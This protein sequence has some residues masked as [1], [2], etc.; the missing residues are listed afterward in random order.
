MHLAQ[1]N[2]QFPGC[3][4]F[5]SY[6]LPVQKKVTTAAGSYVSQAT[7]TSTSNTSISPVID[8]ARNSIIVVENKINNLT[9]NEETMSEQMQEG[10]QAIAR[11]LTRRVTLKDGFDATDLKIYMTANRQS[12]T[13]INCYYK[14]LSQFDA[15]I[16][17]DKYWVLMQ[18]VTNTNTV[19]ASDDDGEY[20]ELEYAPS[21]ANTSY[22]VSTVTYD[23]FKVFAIKI[24]MTS[25]TTTKVPLIKDLRCIALA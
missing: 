6:K 15:D 23:S 5:F 11:Y 20:L 12:G 10:G 1:R 3:C 18:E 13:N 4:F 17:D 22:I 25:P 24:V 14:V 2:F 9:T 19:S 16:F 21:T 8:C 7:L